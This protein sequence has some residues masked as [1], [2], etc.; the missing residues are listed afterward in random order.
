VTASAAPG[1]SAAR[2]RDPRRALRWAAFYAGIAAA[3]FALAAL[4][5]DFT[6]LRLTANLPGDAFWRALCASAPA[7][8]AMLAMWAL[9]ALG[10]MAPAA[11][12][13]LRSY[14]DLVR[15]RAASARGFWA[16]LAG[17]LAVWLAFALCA[18]GAQLGLQRAALVA[19]DGSSTSRALSAALLALAGLYQFTPLKHACLRACRSPL[20]RF[21]GDWRDSVAYAL[22]KGA[23]EGALC[24]G[25]C[26]ALMALGLALGVMNLAFM[27]VAMLV[28]IA[29]KT[30]AL[31]AR[32]SHALGA[33]L[34]A[35][36]LM[37]WL[38][39]TRCLLGRFAVS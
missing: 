30:G 37:L 24:L 6:R 29:E 15:A 4:H 9:M 39:E 8:P 18:A 36:S 17:F 20:A 28:M 25:C 35:A 31:G 21:L 16:L 10:M 23:A 14:D 38:E 19:P 11:A 2:V 5:L 27:G 3:W 7:F 32:G 34:C 13:M 1:A 22:R 26:W 33:A 12:P